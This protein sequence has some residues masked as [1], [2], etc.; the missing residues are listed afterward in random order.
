[1]SYISKDT[2]QK[3]KVSYFSIDQKCQNLNDFD[4]KKIK[5]KTKYK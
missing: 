3:I 4:I 2:D 5:R 1:M